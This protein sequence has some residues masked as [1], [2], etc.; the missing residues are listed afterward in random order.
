MS[1]DLVLAPAT[2]IAERPTP[3]GER[4]LHDALGYIA[5]AD[6]AATRRA[7]AGD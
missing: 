7:Y 1:A 5:R 3:E 2:A 4:A 6:A